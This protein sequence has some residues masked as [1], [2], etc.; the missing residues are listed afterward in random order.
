MSNTSSIN[1]AVLNQ[2]INRYIPI[3]FLLFGKIGNVLNIL[4]FTPKMFRQNICAMYFLASSIFDSFA[5]IIG[6]VPCCL[7]GFGKDPSRKFAILCKLRFFMTYFSIHIAA[8]LISLACVEQ[9]LISSE[10]VHTC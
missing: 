10:N 7:N 1:F 9:Y 3:P 5:I 2:A 6:L 4:I 8:W